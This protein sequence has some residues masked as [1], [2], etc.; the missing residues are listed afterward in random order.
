MGIGALIFTLALIGAALVWSNLPRTGTD[1]LRPTTTA[2][3]IGYTLTGHT[4]WVFGVATAQLDGRTVVISGSADDT[5]RLWDLATGTPVGSP[6]NGHTGPVSSV[7]TA[8]L[9]GRTVVISGSWDKTVRVWDLATGT[10]V[11][12]PFTGHTGP[13][14]AVAT[15]QLDGRTVVISGS[16]DNT[17]RVWDLATGTPVGVPVHRPHRRRGG[18]SDRAAGRTHRGDLRQQRQHGAGVGP[19]HR[20]TGRLPVHRPH[21]LTCRR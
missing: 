20:Q 7:A 1:P 15:A 2:P 5:M 18:G 12:S 10:P 19:G 9:D 6:F 3:A 14:F 17:V 8:Q 11:G 13:V 16:N 21:R 4:N